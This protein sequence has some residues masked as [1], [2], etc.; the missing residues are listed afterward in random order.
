MNLGAV[1]VCLLGAFTPTNV[2]DVGGPLRIRN[3]YPFQNIFLSTPPLDA[4]IPTRKRLDVRL[5]MSNALAY[6]DHSTGTAAGLLVNQNMAAGT[7]IPLD[8]TALAAEAA[9]RPGETF[10][11]AD[12]EVWRLEFVYT[13]PFGRRWALEV[14]APLLAH[15]AGGFD[16]LIEFW[17]DAFA[18]PFDG[19]ENFPSNLGQL[20]YASGTSAMYSG[21]QAGPGI[22]DITLRGIVNLWPDRRWVPATSLSGAVKLPTGD[23]TSFFGSGTWDQGAGLHLTK[24]FGQLNLFGTVGYNHHG[25]WRGMSAVDVRDSVDTHFGWEYRVSP[26]WSVVGGVSLFGSPLHSRERRT[27]KNLAS[28]Y[29]FA[30]RYNDGQ[31]YELEWGFAENIARNNNT[32]DFGLFARLRC[33]P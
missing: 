32:L 19:R 13:H 1:L 21:G 30:A 27:V 18:F 26:K 6:P 7:P 9:T 11:V 12:I 5:A 24:N 31:H 4:R 25:G 22:G 28:N 33:W 10:Y 15:T 20:G 29:A 3:D 16:N 8:W 23:V 2:D 17:H 14:E